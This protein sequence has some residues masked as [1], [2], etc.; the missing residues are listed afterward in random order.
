M[1]RLGT[2][3]CAESRRVLGMCALATLK[4]FLTFRFDLAASSDQLEKPLNHIAHLRAN[5]AWMVRCVCIHTK[6]AVAKR[7][8]AIVRSLALLSCTTVRRPPEQHVECRMRAGSLSEI[9]AWFGRVFR[10]ASVYYI[11]LITVSVRGH[12]K[13]VLHEI[14]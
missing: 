14:R 6:R 11:R 9:F 2:K 5:K 7:S 1:T 3:P 12:W 8:T 10:C 13:V 4:T